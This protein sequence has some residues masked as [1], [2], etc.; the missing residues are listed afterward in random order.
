VI[1]PGLQEKLLEFA[2]DKMLESGRVPEEQLDRHL[3]FP[4]N[5]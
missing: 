5:L 3:N 4:K 2:A 1:D